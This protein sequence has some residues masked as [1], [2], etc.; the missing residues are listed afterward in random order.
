[1][2]QNELDNLQKELE[3][4]RIKHEQEIN[5]IFNDN[6]ESN[7]KLKNEHFKLLQDYNKNINDY[8]ELKFNQIA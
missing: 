5:E 4:K 7:P 1:M 6:N 8:N 2:L 3:D